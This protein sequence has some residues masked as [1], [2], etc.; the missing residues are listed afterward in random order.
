MNKVQT[1]DHLPVKAPHQG[2]AAQQLSQ[3]MVVQPK[4]LTAA[5]LRRRMIQDQMGQMVSLIQRI[6]PRCRIGHVAIC[7]CRR[8]ADYVLEKLLPNVGV[9]C[10]SFVLQAIEFHLYSWMVCLAATVCSSRLQ[11]FELHF[12]TLMTRCT[13]PSTR[14]AMLVEQKGLSS[15]QAKLRHRPVARLSSFKLCILFRLAYCLLTVSL[16]QR[17]IPSC[18]CSA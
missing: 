18:D 14:T 10:Q 15:R 4:V 8:V 17:R 11:C 12:V 9:L 1:K 3:T 16:Q 2:M 13:L 6:W 5:G 7:I